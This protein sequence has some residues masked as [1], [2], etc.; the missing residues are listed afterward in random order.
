MRQLQF[1]SGNPYQTTYMRQGGFGTLGGPNI[2]GLVTEV[3]TRALKAVW[4]Q[5]WLVHRRLRPEAYGGLMQ[6][7]AIGSEGQTRDYGLPT[8]A[9]ETK[10]AQAVRT[11]W[12]GGG[13]FLPMAYSAG[14]VLRIPPTVQVTPVSPARASRS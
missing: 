10:A 12:G 6:L 1:N 4:R 11:L 5:K 7:Q 14:A 2:L 9:F 3:S 13:Y 8:W